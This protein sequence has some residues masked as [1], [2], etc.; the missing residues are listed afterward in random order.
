[1]TNRPE[2]RRDLLHRNLSFGAVIGAGIGGLQ[3]L[4]TQPD[5]A[6]TTVMGHAAG[7]AIGGAVIFVLVSAIARWVLR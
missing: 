1:M 7:G 3:V 5:A 6:I 2:D 4:T